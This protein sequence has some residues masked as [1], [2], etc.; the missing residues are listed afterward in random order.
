MFF[1]PFS[2][3][4][5][6]EAKD[7]HTTVFSPL[8]LGMLEMQWEITRKYIKQDLGASRINIIRVEGNS[9]SEPIPPLT[10]P[11]PVVPQTMFYSM[12]DPTQMPFHRHPHVCGLLI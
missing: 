4:I 5:Y 1:S 3:P 6:S 2:T 8:V 10:M 12:A 9:S 11:N 7:D